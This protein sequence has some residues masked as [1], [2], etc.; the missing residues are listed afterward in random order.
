M[1]R[2]GSAGMPRAPPAPGRQPLAGSGSRASPHPRQRGRSAPRRAEPSRAQE[3]P[4]QRSPG[5]PSRAGAASPR[6]PAK[7]TEPQSALLTGSSSSCCQSRQ[8]AAIPY[9]HTHT[10]PHGH[11]AP[12]PETPTCKRKGGRRRGGEG[13]KHPTT[14]SCTHARSQGPHCPAG[15]PP[16]PESESLRGRG[17]WR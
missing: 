3:S 9:T 5:E 16:S 2:L 15:I 8:P 7:L 10:H 1:A 14:F 11:P 12:A 17:G 4:A 6:R 13:K